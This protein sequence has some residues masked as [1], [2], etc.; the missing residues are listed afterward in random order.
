MLILT[1]PI[2][3][4][5]LRAAQLVT[6]G[7]CGGLGSSPGQL[8]LLAGL[9]NNLRLIYSRCPRI[10]LFIYIGICLWMWF[11]IYWSFFSYHFFFASY[12]FLSIFLPTHSLSFTFRLLFYFFFITFF[13]L[14]FPPPFLYYHIFTFSFLFFP[15]SFLLPRIFVLFS[16]SISILFSSFH[17]FAFL[18][19]KSPIA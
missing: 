4:A 16:S 9:K 2:D 11:L 5:Y 3:A 7:S 6:W 13:F 14:L 12:L 8:N 10:Y 19:P 17:S 15:H 18:T 1:F